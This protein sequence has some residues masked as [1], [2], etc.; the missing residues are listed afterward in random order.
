MSHVFAEIPISL[1]AN[2]DLNTLVSQ[3][4]DIVEHAPFH[5]V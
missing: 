4:Q 1:E 3:F 2:E 5:I